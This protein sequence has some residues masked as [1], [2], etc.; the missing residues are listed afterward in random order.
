MDAQGLARAIGRIS[1]KIEENKDYLVKL[2]QQNG[3]G[4]LGISMNDGFKA[5]CMIMEL[6]EE[7]DLGKLLMKAGNAFN[8]AAPSSLGTI[9]SFGFM[10]MARSLKG[11]IDATPQQI[12]DA[13]HAGVDKIM[14]KAGSR[15]GER[16][17][18]DSLYPA[19]ETLGKKL[20]EENGDLYKAM[21]EAARIAAVGAEAT[22]QM[23]PVHGRAAYY[24]EKSLGYLDGGAVV[25]KLI[26]E[27][28]CGD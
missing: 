7:K 20:E 16:T 10:G 18:L 28:L 27:A 19:V 24:G 5:V 15:P 17:I 13:L 9:L 8:E 22:K 2:D 26:F 25:G 4:D 11:T 1:R 14:E 23:K 6:S 21:K 3:D 12:A